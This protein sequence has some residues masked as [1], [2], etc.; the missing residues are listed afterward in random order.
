MWGRHRGTAS[1]AMMRI[2]PPAADT[3][4]VGVVAG[5][6]WLTFVQTDDLDDWE[7]AHGVILNPDGN[8]VLERGGRGRELRGYSTSARARDTTL[9]RTPSPSIHPMKGTSATQDMWTTASSPSGV[10]VSPLSPHSAIPAG[11]GRLAT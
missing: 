3:N 5:G 10:P 9:T 7:L 11:M 1:Q 6:D 4:V 2:G 8:L